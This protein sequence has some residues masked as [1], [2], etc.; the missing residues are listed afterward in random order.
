[1]VILCLAGAM[2][3]S[4]SGCSDILSVFAVSDAPGD[5]TFSDVCDKFKEAKTFDA[6]IFFTLILSDDTSSYHFT[7]AINFTMDEVNEKPVVYLYSLAAYPDSVCYKIDGTLVKIVDGEVVEAAVSDLFP[8]PSYLSGN[9]PVP[10]PPDTSKEI[11][12]A[13]NAIDSL[14]FSSFAYE[15]VAAPVGSMGF[16]F[17]LD[18]DSVAVASEALDANGFFNDMDS[19]VFT[20]ITDNA[21]KL[22]VSIE[23][24]ASGSAV[25]RVK[26]GETST[27]VPYDFSVYYK[28]A[29]K[30]YDKEN[31][32]QYPPEITAYLE[33]PE[34]T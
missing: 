34:E 26:N 3:F 8:V 12:N 21:T 25:V 23:I 22:P 31:P 2:V 6:D 5:Y 20:F 10:I 13:L 4:A 17:T 29:Y 14:N 11:Y 30:S 16:Q 7:S 27:D 32:V 9:Q 1:M 24:N 18:E 19:C 33:N 28:I 15:E